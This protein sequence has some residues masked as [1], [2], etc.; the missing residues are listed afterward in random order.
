MLKEFKKPNLNAPRYVAKT[1]NTL[2]PVFFSRLRKQHPELK[3]YN[4]TQLRKVIKISNEQIYKDMLEFRNGVEFPESL[5]FGFIGTCPKKISDNIDY[6]LSIEHRQTIQHRNWESD[7]YLAKIFFTNYEAKYRFKFHDLWTF[8]G[9]RNFTRDV[10]KIYPTRWKQYIQVDHSLKISRLFRKEK[11]K[12]YQ[13]KKTETLLQTYD[14][15][16]GFE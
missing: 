2:T 4:D 5:G 7:S 12:N 3:I 6:A 15:F 13:K 10:G 16:E 8:S 9:G 11:N 14:E 1:F